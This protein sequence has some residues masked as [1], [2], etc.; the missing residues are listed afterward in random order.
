MI[1]TGKGYVLLYNL[2]PALIAQVDVMRDKIIFCSAEP[3]I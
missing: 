3:R 2:R 1:Q